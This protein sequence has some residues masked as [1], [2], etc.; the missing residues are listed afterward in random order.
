LETKRVADIKNHHSAS[1][2]PETWQVNDRH[3]AIGNGLESLSAAALQPRWAIFN[4]TIA[5]RRRSYKGWV[6]GF[7]WAFLLFSGIG[8]DELSSSGQTTLINMP[9]ARI[10]PDDIFRLGASSSDPYL[11]I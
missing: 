7:S 5:A 10:A 4:R 9:D 3:R 11:P 1:S 2:G 6:I 8:A